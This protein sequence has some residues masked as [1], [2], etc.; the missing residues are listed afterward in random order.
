MQH[1]LEK[2]K[3]L[4]IVLWEEMSCSTTE[5][6]IM[7]VSGT[8]VMPLISLLSLW[9]LVQHSLQWRL[10]LTECV[11]CFFHLQSDVLHPIEPTTRS[12]WGN[13]CD[14]SETCSVSCSTIFLNGDV[15]LSEWEEGGNIFHFKKLHPCDWF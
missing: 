14:A 5:S 15:H 10:S 4:N 3:R 2:A 7:H 9:R 8:W 12:G 13:W 11:L 6:S 1:N